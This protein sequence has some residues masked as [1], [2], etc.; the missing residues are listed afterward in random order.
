MGYLI[1]CVACGGPHALDAASCKARKSDDTGTTPYR[2]AEADR[3]ERL[4][5]A[6]YDATRQKHA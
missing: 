6:R 5:I 1:N 3:M 2:Q 4:A